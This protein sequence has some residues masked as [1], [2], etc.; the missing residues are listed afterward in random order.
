MPTPVFLLVGW[1]CSSGAVDDPW[2]H[3]LVDVTCADVVTTAVRELGGRGELLQEAVVLS[4]GE[5]SAVPGQGD[6]ALFTRR[7]PEAVRGGK[8]EAAW[9]ELT[10]LRR[11]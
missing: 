6:P 11:D 4:R 8:G 7:R 5:R 1:A 10:P 3:A 2:V 9:A